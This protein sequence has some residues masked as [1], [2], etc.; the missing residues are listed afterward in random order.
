[1][2]EQNEKKDE[3]IEFLKLSK[4]KDEE[5]KDIRYQLNYSRGANK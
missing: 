4:T 2:Q 5:V 1:L 3:H